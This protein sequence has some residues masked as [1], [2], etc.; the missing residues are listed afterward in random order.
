MWEA[1]SVCLCPPCYLLPLL[2]R[3]GTDPRHLPRELW[4][5]LQGQKVPHLI[6]VVSSLALPK[7]VPRVIVKLTRVMEAS[8]RCGNLT[9]NQ[10][11]W[12]KR[13]DLKWLLMNGWQ[14]VDQCSGLN[15]R[16]PGNNWYRKK[17]PWPFGHMNMGSKSDEIW[18]T[19]C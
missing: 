14:Q 15:K 3:P 1:M 4:Y 5:Q 9:S 17:M 7:G 18:E 2:D 8:A 6:E 12:N 16:N 10:C 19:R 11:Y 13:H